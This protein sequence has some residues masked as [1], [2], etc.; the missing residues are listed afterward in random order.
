[1]GITIYLFVILGKWLDVKFGNSG[2]VFLIVC[3]LFGVAISLYAVLK[4]IKKL[5]P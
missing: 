1:M 3:T 2:K 5:N 4:Q